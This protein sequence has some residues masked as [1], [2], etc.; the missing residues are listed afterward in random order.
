MDALAR[1]RLFDDSLEGVQ[2]FDRQWR[3]CYINKTAASQGRAT[4][5]ALLGQCF[6][7][8]Y[9]GVAE[10]ELYQHLQ[11]CMESRLPSRL[12]N[13]FEFADGEVCWFELRM[14]PVEEGVL[15]MSLD[16]TAHKKT[17]ER[18][19][20]ANEQLEAR[21]QEKTQALEGAYAQLS[22]ELE[23]RLQKSLT[24][25]ADY[26]HALDESCIVAITDQKGVIKHVNENFCSISQY[27][28][29]ELLGK[30]H[31]IIN[32]AFHPKAFIRDLWVTIANG[33]I[34]RGELRNQA[35]DGSFYWVDT[36]IVPFL[37]EKGKPYQYL[38]IRSDITARKLAEEALLR[39]NE[40]LENKVTERTLELTHALEREKELNDMKSRFVSMASHEFRTPLSAILSSTTLLE[41]YSGTE[42]AEKRVKHIERIKSSVRNLTSILDDFLSLEKLEQGKV[43]THN[44]TFELKDALEDAIDEL[45]GQLKRKGQTIQFNY[46]GVR[47]VCQ[48]RKILRNVLLNLLSN[49]SKYSKE[50]TFIELEAIVTEEEAQIR[51]RDHGIGIPV[52]AQQHLFEKFYRAPNAVNIQ[53][54]GLG[55]NIVRRYV[56]LLQGTIDFTSLEGMGTTFI[57]TFPR[58]RK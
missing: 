11:N 48:D 31:R 15:V 8:M 2:V 26:K 38:A 4:R 29:E 58:L 32:S 47:D 49:A 54:T 57:L 28:R 42:Q 56:E 5:E 37:D 7:D 40:L 14:Q 46:R 22:Q 51:V 55:L 45:E 20:K 41:H 6:L 17:E 13:R 44:T 3:Y 19:Q 9:P 50:E 36:T 30:D 34:W 10:T 24:E 43:E 1:Y 53:G 35:K 12:L 21:V 18:L 25:I 33:H 52:D 23:Q 27:T 16:V 39:S